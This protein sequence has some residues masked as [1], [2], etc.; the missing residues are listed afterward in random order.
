VCKTLSSCLSRVI[1]LKLANNYLS[2]DGI[3]LFLSAYQEMNQIIPIDWRE[4]DIS[5]SIEKRMTN[6]IK[7]IP[8]I[9]ILT[10]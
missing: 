2:D 4:N 6:L 1:F 9:Q 3:N 5:W 10:L 7:T 8:T